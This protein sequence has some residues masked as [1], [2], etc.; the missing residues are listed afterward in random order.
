[1]G[2]NKVHDE[3]VLVWY[4]KS[5]VNPQA[6]TARII[7]V[8]RDYS[9]DYRE[10]QTQYNISYMYLFEPGRSIM[11]SGYS[12]LKGKN[13]Y[14][15]FDISFSS[16]FWSK[17][18]SKDN[19][20]RAV[21]GTPFQYCTWEKYTRYPNY[22]YI[23]DMTEFFDLASRYP[24]IEYLTKMGFENLVF[25]KLMRDQTYGAI[26]WNGK[27]IFEVLRLNKS[28]LNEIRKSQMK[29]KP[30]ELRYYQ[31]SKKKNLELS[32][33]E[34]VML[35]ELETPIFKEYMDDIQK[36]TS[37]KKAVK[38]ILKQL[39]TDQYRHGYNVVVDWK[40]YMSQCREF[41]I[42][43]SEERNLFPNNLHSA[44]TKLTARMKMKKD[45]AIN[46]KI[47]DRSAVLKAYCFEKNG[48]LLRPAESTAELFIEGRSLQHCVGQYA[49]QHA[50]GRTAIFFIRRC[51]EPDKPFYTL[52]LRGNQIVQC[53]GYKR[54]A[55]T[56]EVENF[57]N[58]FKQEKLM[59]NKKKMEVAV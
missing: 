24:C 58:L 53:Q 6:I 46:K 30:I 17:H 37:E 33:H 14:S 39:R 51:E 45:K 35:S 25:A 3:A 5:K 40:D 16:K 4:E 15:G 20:Q 2:R 49:D 52:E 7:S 19:I 56:P 18:V 32:I 29:L 47:M 36:L 12:K 59:S 8:V 48:L 34:A 55:M 9:G 13:V 42:D 11:F 10:V 38:Y 43:L 22:R 1:M 23:S 28:E 44:H 41:R 21:K 57:V 31:K 27:N 54:V 50:S 26:H